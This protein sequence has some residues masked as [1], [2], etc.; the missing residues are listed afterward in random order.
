MKVIAD[1][2]VIPITGSVSL[3]KEVARAHQILKETGL[4]IQLHSY[5]TNIEGD[6]DIVMAA[7]KEIHQEL[8]TVGI[9]R[10]NTTIKLG[11]RTDKSQSL[12]DKIHAVEQEL[13]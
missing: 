12:K 11:T 1:I 3:R 8:H 10:I 4:P 13:Q 9:Q 6:F 5:G 2:C 7:V